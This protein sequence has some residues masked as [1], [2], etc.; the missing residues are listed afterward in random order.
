MEITKETL[1]AAIAST[2]QQLA[3]AMAEADMCRGSIIACNQLLEHLETPDPPSPTPPS[4]ADVTFEGA[5]VEG[6]AEGR[7]C[8][9]EGTG[10]ETTPEE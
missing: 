1:E 6:L 8:C 2:E 3:K 7:P 4:F 9:G 10:E 5:S